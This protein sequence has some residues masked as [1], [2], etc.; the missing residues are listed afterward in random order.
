VKQSWSG[1]EGMLL[2]AV[3]A[4][5]AQPSPPVA[6]RPLTLPKILAPRRLV[7][8]SLSFAYRPRGMTGTTEMSD[9][10]FAMVIRRA[11]NAS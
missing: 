7:D 3:P 4:S 6:A 11:A 5:S 10:L 8:V 9:P 1:S 2:M